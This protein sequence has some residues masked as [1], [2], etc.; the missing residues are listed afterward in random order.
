MPTWRETM[1]RS[2]IFIFFILLLIA[3]TPCAAFSDPPVK[4]LGIDQ[5]LSNNGVISIFQ[6][7]NG[8]MWFGTFDGLNRYDGYSFKVFRNVLS[9]TTSLK[10]NYI[11][12]MA[13][14]L[15]HHLWVGTAKGVNV[16]NPVKANF[17]N[18]KFRSSDNTS[19]K[20]L[21]NSISAIQQND[22]DGC[23]LVGAHNSGLLIFEKN[24][25]TGVQIPFLSWKGHEDEYDVT[26]M[27]LDANRQLAWVFIQE[28][29]L[30]LYNIKSKELKLING[31]IKKAGCL[32]LDSNGNLWLGNENGLFNYDISTNVF[33]NNVLPFRGRVMHL[34]EDRQHV[35]WISCDG[36]GVWSMRVGENRPAVYLSASGTSLINGN[37]IYAI[38]DDLQGNKWVATKHGGITMIQL[39]RNLFNHITYAGTGQK[40]SIE[41]FI[42]CFAEDKKGNVWIGTDG[43]GLRYW[44]R[45]NDTSITYRHDAS[46]YATISSDFITNVVCD[47]QGDLWAVSWLGGVNRLKKGS[48]NFEHF[49]CY[50][51]YTG[52][53]DKNAWLVFEDSRKQ[54][55]V[56]TAN[57]GA[58]Y[59]FNRNTNR[60]EVFDEKLTTILCIAEDRQGNILA[61]YRNS[62]LQ[63]DLVNKKH[64]LWPVGHS[65][66]SIC[67]DRN[68]NLWVGTDGGGLLL[69]DCTKGT[70]EQYTTSN[71]LPSNTI[72]RM[73]EDDKNNLWLST[74]NGLC[75]FNTIHRTFR[76]YSKSDGLQSTQFG[77]N[78][79]LAL[80]SGEFVF[81][82][83]KGFNIFYPDSIYDKKEPFN[84]YLT[85]LKINNK[86][87]E[88]D[89]SYVSKRASD[90]IETIELPFD[91]A[92]L[93]LD[94]VALDYV[95]ADNI[96]YAYKLEGWD[97]NWIYLNNTRTANYSRLHEGTYSFK[98]KVSNGAGPWSEAASL[99]TV[100]VLPPWYRTWWAYCM[101]AVLV[102]SAAYLYII[103]NKRHERLRYEIKLA[104]YEKEKEKELTEKKLS[105]FTHI[106]HEFRAPLT[107]IINPIKDLIQKIDTPDE[108]Q[109][110]NIV[111]RNA[112]RLLSLIDQLLLF[113]KADAAIDNLKFSRHN[114]YQLCNEVF[115]CFLQQAKANNQEYLFEFE[116]QDLELYVDR[117]KIE[118]ALF[119]L[120][121][122][123]I[124]Y[125]PEHGKII[126]RVTETNEEVNIAVIDNGHGISGEAA[127]RLFEKFYQS[128]SPKAPAKSGFGIGLYVVDR[129]VRAHNGAVT[130]HTEEG[131]GTTFLVTLKKDKKHLKEQLIVNEPLKEKT[132]LLTE[133]TE[134]VHDETVVS[135][136]TAKTE[137]LVTDRQTILLA[138]DDDAIRRYLQQI[139]KHKYE[140]L[141]A[142]NGMEALKTAQEKFPDLV[143]SDIRMDG[144]NGIELCR[145]IKQDQNLNH[146]PVILLTG[147]N[148]DDVELQSIE[149]GA[150]AYIT[151]PFDKDILLAKVENLFNSRSELQKYFFNEVTLQKNTLKISPEYKAFLDK[152]IAIVEQH[153]HD[154]QFS[155]KVLAQEIGMSHSYLY[156]KVK[157]MSGQSVAGF[158]R[159]IRLKKSAELMIKT[160]CNVNDAAFQVG[161]NDAKYFRRQFN[162]LFG[163]NPSEYIKKYRD[164]FNKAYQISTKV[165]KEKPKD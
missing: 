106:S 27:T 60:F 2:T 57:G 17:Y 11:R 108:Q 38:Y 43:A 89:D 84:I 160:N 147:S 75:K 46:N 87:V 136:S 153:L 143:I 161:F 68:K 111:H 122:N 92:I 165:L 44:D 56:T 28:A 91:E 138:D 49:S 85:E 63:I 80:R 150:D 30:C 102:V 70:Y 126:F 19:L 77:F 156:K 54:L 152:C 123:A 73:L 15:N 51:S 25:A 29:G 125:T 93:S 155:I 86:P 94:Y 23:M 121:S 58:L 20:P 35:L 65:V 24:S 26:A 78:A 10:S 55:W 139:L 66:R 36:N 50:N 39:R 134:D 119:N 32:K 114:F 40:N 90:R 48:K 129:F 124:K 104:N 95:A 72:L 99:L 141:E 22:K 59:V 159:Y 42:F 21:E 12:V 157:L 132:A 113:R 130:F 142:E 127:S 116:N 140:L 103:Y 37:S 101:Y 4:Y 154:D 69:F 41:D 79:A 47:S 131:K 61:G 120:I 118:I 13:E 16:Y 45:T 145:Q 71:G 148:G 33:S 162:I 151:K 149:G 76:N 164:P 97:K 6:D 8:F 158:I 74:Y 112:R 52:I 3:R 18:A 109:E 81:G 133:L 98:I 62:L 96:K 7:H 67:E 135:E 64:R 9:D 146:I 31:S 1:F 53:V 163:M 5:G 144:L 14:D 34:F 107:L 115:I 128:S 88:E 100:V 105:F 110:L 83:I 117:E 82:G 137:E